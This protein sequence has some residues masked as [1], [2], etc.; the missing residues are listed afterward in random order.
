MRPRR[1]ASDPPT[2]PAGSGR[3]SLRPTHAASEAGAPPR[4]PA[5][6]RARPSGVC[7]GAASRRCSRGSRWASSADAHREPREQTPSPGQARTKTRSR[8]CGA[9]TAEAGRH[10]HSASNPRSAKSP[11]TQPSARRCGT[12]AAPPPGCSHTPRAEFQIAMGSGTGQT[13]DV[14]D[15]HEGGA[16][17]AYGAGDVRPDTGT[18]SRHQARALAREGQVGAGEPGGEDVHRFDGA[19][20][21][22]G[23]VPVVRDARPVV[24]HDPRGV[25]VPVGFAV[26]VRRLVLGV[27]GQFGTGEHGLDGQVEHADAG[28]EGT[29]AQGHSA[30]PIRHTRTTAPGLLSAPGKPAYSFPVRSYHTTCASSAHTTPVSASSVER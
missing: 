21:D 29:D 16:Q 15:Q 14:L 27:P 17:C 26:L 2:I 6:A 5:S 3:P 11:R 18:R 10:V 28:A 1:A 13:P 7:P 20:V 19:I 23:D 8:L 9:P 12:A 4:P 22:R 25:L 30:P 24:R